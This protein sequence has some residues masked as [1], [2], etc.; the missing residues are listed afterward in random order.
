MVE[1]GNDKLSDGRAFHADYMWESV[2]IKTL[3]IVIR[4]KCM[5][6]FSSSCTSGVRMGEWYMQWVMQ[7]L[8]EEAFRDLT[9]IITSYNSNMYI[10]GRI[11]KLISWL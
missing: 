1:V 8:D 3:C 11:S 9:K 7:K 6:E 5:L 4:W 2:K 10:M